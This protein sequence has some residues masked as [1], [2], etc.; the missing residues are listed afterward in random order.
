MRPQASKETMVGNPH[1]DLVSTVSKERRRI[2]RAWHRRPVPH[3]APPSREEVTPFAQLGTTK[4]P[5]AGISSQLSVSIAARSCVV[6]RRQTSSVS[7]NARQSRNV[8]PVSYARGSEHAKTANSTL[9][10]AG[11]LSQA[12]DGLEPSTPSL[13]SGGHG[14]ARAVTFLLQIEPSR[15]VDRVRACPRV[16]NLSTRLVPAALAVSKTSNIERGIGAVAVAASRAS[17]PGD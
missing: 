15:R 2:D 3:R 7:A 4:R 16:L 12:F 14:R 1:P 11:I 10:F 8:E 9:R 6:T 13:P 17:I 5:N